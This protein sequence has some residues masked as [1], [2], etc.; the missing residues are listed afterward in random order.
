MYFLFN[1]WT[2]TNK[3]LSK[4]IK[5]MIKVILLNIK[6]IIW[7]DGFKTVLDNFSFSVV[8]QLFLIEFN[9]N[10]HSSN[11]LQISNFPNFYLFSLSIFGIIKT[12]K[13]YIFIKKK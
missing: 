10:F 5:K 2:L 3:N 8:F 1:N 7:I 13:I 11:F 9:K 12:I 4:N 6:I